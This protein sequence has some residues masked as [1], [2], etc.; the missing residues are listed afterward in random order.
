MNMVSKCLE[1]CEEYDVK[2]NLAII[3]QNGRDK[4]RAKM[5]V[6]RDFLSNAYNGLKRMQKKFGM[7]L[8][9]LN[10]CARV[11]ART[12]AYAQDLRAFIDLKLTGRILILIMINM[13]E[14]LLSVMKIWS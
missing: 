5:R 2:E 3:F 13:N 4:K 11:N 7:I 1:K 8:S 9:I 10:F 6:L 14:K 12:N